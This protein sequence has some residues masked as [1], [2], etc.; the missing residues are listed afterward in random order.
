MRALPD[1]KGDGEET[2]SHFQMMLWDYID[3]MA[4]KA[5]ASD[6]WTHDDNMAVQ[7]LGW[8]MYTVTAP[9]T[10][11]RRYTLVSLDRR[12]SGNDVFN[13]IK[14]VAPLCPL[15]SKALGILTAQKLKEG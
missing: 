2:I 3:V 4:E 8:G 6:R 13:R 1:K 11:D 14:Q 9:D 5:G 10:N 7:H 15:C 12:L